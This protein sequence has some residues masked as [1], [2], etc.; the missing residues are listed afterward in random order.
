[1]P[2]T[3]RGGLTNPPEMLGICQS[4]ASLREH[5]L[6]LDY[7]MDTFF[8]NFELWSG[9]IAAVFL[10][11]GV[12][13]AGAPIW[14]SFMVAISLFAGLYLI[15]S[16]WLDIQ[17]QREAGR[18]TLERMKAGIAEGQ[19]KLDEIR[20]LAGRIGQVQ[21]RDQLFRICDIGTR[22]FHNL[23]DDPSHLSKSGRFLLYLD[24]FLP[25]IEKYAR[26]TSSRTGIEMI[27][28]DKEFL[29]T[30][31]S[32]EQGFEQGLRNYLERDVVEIKTAGRILK[33][34]MNVA[35]IGE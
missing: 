29:E 6:K 18:M 11:A 5:A 28:S 26:V 4:Q 15:G 2:S 3:A 25:L 17:I 30:L 16:F 33:K 12:F 9:G 21:I 13:I 24:R 20:R 23:K 32:I 35:E 7:N 14:L 34:M 10:L 31:G 22:I 19:K 1:M 27:G 8:K